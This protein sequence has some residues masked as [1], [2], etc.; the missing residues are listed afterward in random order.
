MKMEEMEGRVRVRLKWGGGQR[1]S[2]NGRRKG[3]NW[4]GESRSGVGTQHIRGRSGGCVE[5]RLRKH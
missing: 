4:R 1:R 3:W 2:C 5:L